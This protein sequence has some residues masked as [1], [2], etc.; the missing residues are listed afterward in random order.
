MHY[1]KQTCLNLPGHLC[2]IGT[3][4]YLFRKRD[5]I[6][7]NQRGADGTTKIMGE[8]TALEKHLIE[9]QDVFEIRG[10][11]RHGILLS[12]ADYDA[13]LTYILPLNSCHLSGD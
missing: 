8:L 2:L 7:R 10:K 4:G 11:V 9:S 1:Q 5:Y 6:A 13:L 12:S 3:F